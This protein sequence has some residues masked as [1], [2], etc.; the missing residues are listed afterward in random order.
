[1]ND[2][3]VTELKE[4]QKNNFEAIPVRSESLLW[5]TAK[6]GVFYA[7]TGI[8]LKKTK[9]TKDYSDLMA[10]GAVASATLLNTNE[11]EKYSDDFVALGS[12]LAITSGYKGFKNLLS[13]KDFYDKT[14][15]FLDKADDV[16]KKMKIFIPEVW[17][18]TTD[19]LFNG[20]ISKGMEKVKNFKTENPE[21][22]SFSTIVHG[23][24]SFAKSFQESLFETFSSG[25]SQIAEKKWAIFDDVI[26]NSNFGKFKKLSEENPEL[27]VY[28][29]TLKKDPLN[30]LDISTESGLTFTDNLLN[31]KF[32]K[33]FTKDFIGLDTKEVLENEELLKEA[34]KQIKE[35]QR[36]NKINNQSFFKDFLGEYTIY[37]N[38]KK[39]A[40]IG[41]ILNDGNNYISSYNTLLDGFY[42]ENPNIDK[43]ADDLGE[44]FLKWAENSFYS[45]DSSDKKEDLRK[46]INSFY[47]QDDSIKIADLEKYVG[48]EFTLDK[49]KDLIQEENKL[50]DIGIMDYIINSNSSKNKL[51]NVEINKVLNEDTNQYGEV[52]KI[53]GINNFEALKNFKLTDV[54]KYEDGELVDKTIGDSSLLTYRIGGIVEN[55]ISAHYKVNN[56]LSKATLKTWNPMSL[57][58]SERRR[59]QY[60]AN[61][62]QK[63]SISRE[64]GS[65]LSNFIINGVKFGTYDFEYIKDK[66][67]LPNEVIRHTGNILKNKYKELDVNYMNPEKGKSFHVYDK[68]IDLIEN[69]FTE[70]PGKIIEF[71]SNERA[72]LNSELTNALKIA[73]ASY[74]DKLGSKETKGFSEY[75]ASEIFEKM[76]SNNNIK[77]KVEDV[78]L[79]RKQF[80]Y[81]SSLKDDNYKQYYLKKV[82]DVATE[83][84]SMNKEYKKRANPNLSF[85]KSIRENIHEFV[86]S[87]WNP[88]PIRYDKKNKTY[89]FISAYDGS[90]KEDETLLHG[91]VEKVSRGKITVNQKF[92]NNINLKDII[93]SNKA[94][95]EQ[96]SIFMKDI[97]D[98]N[99][100]NEYIASSFIEPFKKILNKNDQSNELFFSLQKV[101]QNKFNEGKLDQ[102]Y[103]QMLFGNLNKIYQSNLSLNEK[104][105]F[106][107]N[108]INGLD[109][110][111]IP[112]F[113][114]IV[115]TSAS[116]SVF[117][118]ILNNT[119]VDGNIDFSNK[120]FKEIGKK[121]NL[122]NDND[123]VNIIKQFGI[124]FL[125]NAKK[126]LANELINNINSKTANKLFQ[127]WEDY[128]N[129]NTQAFIEAYGGDNEAFLKDKNNILRGKNFILDYLDARKQ[130]V[131]DTYNFNQ[132]N[133]IKEFIYNE[134]VDTLNNNDITNKVTNNY[135]N[136]S[137]INLANRLYKVAK[138]H[139][140]VID[141]IYE[142]SDDNFKIG[143]SSKDI[144]KKYDFFDNM[145][146][147][148]GYIFENDSKKLN[149]AKKLAEDSKDIIPV[150]TF[151]DL[152][153]EK[154]VE[155]F[156]QT[157]YDV[158][159]KQTSS[160]ILRNGIEL[161]K[162]ISGMFE[163][164]KEFFFSDTEEKQIKRAKNIRNITY[165][166]ENIAKGKVI[167]SKSSYGIVE[168]DTNINN[169]FRGIFSSLE[170]SFEQLGFERFSNGLNREIHW[171]KRTKDILLKRFGVMSG[172][173]LGGLAINSFT[174][175]LL[176]DQIPLIGKGPIATGA[177]LYSTARVGLQ[178]AFNY[179]GISSIGR[180]VD[181][182]SN[183]MLSVFPF[184]P[185]ITTDAEEMKD[186][187]FNGKAIRVNKNRFWFTAGRQ[188][189]EG[190]EFDQYRPHVLYTLMNP[191]TGV[192]AM[193]NGYLGKWQKFFRKDFL[194]TKYPWYLIDPYREER[195]AYKKY[196][197]LYPVTEQLFKDIPIVGDFM[198][199]TIGQLIKPTQYINEEEWLYKDNYIK[200]PSY[201][202]NDEFSPKY[203]EFSKTEGIN[204]IIP[205]LFGAIEDVKTFAGLKGY[206][207]GKATEFLFGKTNPYEKK[208]TL[209]SISDD[210][211]Y[212]SEYNKYNIG[213][214]FDLT[215]PIRRFI[216]EHN[217]LGTTV[218]NPLKQKLPYWMPNYFKQGRNP[219]MTYNFGTYIGPTDDF[220]NTINHING[221][222]NL[223]RFRILSMIAPKSKEFEEMKTRI[224]NKITDLSEKEKAH[225]YESLSYASEYGTRKYATENEKVGS[226]KDISVTIKEKLSPYEFIGTDNKRYKLDTVTE[227]FN[228]L[229]SRYGRTKATKLMSDL[230]KTFS[231]GKTYNFSMALSANYAGGID[232]E[233]DFFRVDSELVSNR[234]NLDNSPYRNKYK[235]SNIIS[236]NLRRT[237]QNVASPMASEKLFGRKTVYEEWGVE[238]VQTNY[239][240]DW[241]SPI[242]SFIAP[243]FT[244][245]SN[246]VI[247]GTT[248]QL[249]TEKAFEQSN[250]DTNYLKG[251]IS[252]GR[253]NYFK[254]AITGNVTTSLDYKRDTEVQDK[255]EQFKLLNGKKNIY[256]LTGKEYLANVNK[257]VNEQDSKFLKDLLNVK[258]K[259][260]REL[261]LKTGNDRLKTVL[262]MIWNRQQQAINGETLYENW[263]MEAPK[264]L[265]TKGVEYTSNQEQL[266]NKIKFSL[267]YKYSK[268]EA[269]RQGIYNA[270][271]GSSS[272]EEAR[273]IRNKMFEQY[274]IQSQ[275]V[276]TIYPS[277][278]IFM[279][280]F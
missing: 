268:L 27:A 57:I 225:Y 146:K 35:F 53:T 94:L 30:D 116:K 215:E 258:N 56:L 200:N 75:S 132:N 147:K 18:R 51:F 223:N 213:G 235:I 29:K 175:A 228:K 155:I 49:T 172:F 193:D 1:M 74:L 8:A 162:G 222:E 192:R 174:D 24:F 17:N 246:S 151:N 90:Y 212:A 216:D 253:L 144:L 202:S 245:P 270:Y 133:D 208:I 176:P 134:I 85:R 124:N 199:A 122:F 195:I 220:N 232:D 207:L 125:S 72:T 267:G 183:G 159:K 79:N 157:F 191:T 42:L 256:Q 6:L 118:E 138:K 5:K 218:I 170:D 271:V 229:S 188:S 143:L 196:G 48:K 263:Q 150:N 11:Q 110:S 31:N 103:A 260:E 160:V 63:M 198:S 131:R 167:L 115:N 142:N 224:L 83:E 173:V 55:F 140:E 210:I 69:G 206:A 16:T 261:I 32:L 259:K 54:V 113:Q 12:L 241:D 179:T 211:S 127:N 9:L 38:G 129:K 190:E 14:Y 203:L 244:I 101:V 73:S 252:L 96:A 278:Q 92:S 89:K 25:F 219:M 108:N 277:G 165:I 59:K 77:K 88:L 136:F 262:K 10:F 128:V 33:Q 47:D 95:E 70:I 135:K 177:M 148:M 197:A 104:I 121:L 269:K 93:G 82:V 264:T 231:V 44:R 156:R 22:G 201:D 76:S 78:F 237:F 64:E 3:L 250:S 50:N 279:N 217:S 98:A 39:T 2:E 242:S 43:N 36:Y 240:R 65:E 123:D 164:L 184:I 34:Q 112:S 186:Q 141:S 126:E 52:Y 71:N 152:S 181:N 119:N 226:T 114:A 272:D 84:I 274:G 58:D 62:I 227:D 166:R 158:N 19:S 194:P 28:L 236:S 233:G 61:N 15:N 66:K 249:E 107:K 209:A 26:E 178:Y 276:S 4:E 21:S 169:F 234:L 180:W 120:T 20:T 87:D 7:L 265:D 185:D 182:V 239:F 37:E 273:Y 163:S 45:G 243:Y 117:K 60:I 230:D 97:V 91:L 105:S 205:S 247:S 251:L 46:V 254:N 266:K 111:L 257:M 81:T 168:T 204:G 40:N 68:V 280:Q 100:N 161:D 145:S 106:L 187:F 154:K 153:L 149:I 102:N 86:N 23:A 255:I 109:K 99:I 13:D 137:E 130:S 139:S 238:A 80:F 67:D 189:I 248:F 171:T 275:T 41:K 221:N 214:A